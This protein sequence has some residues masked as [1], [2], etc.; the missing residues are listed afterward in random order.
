MIIEIERREPERIELPC[1]RRN[2]RGFL[3]ADQPRNRLQRLLRR[4]RK[5]AQREHVELRK[6]RGRLGF[7]PPISGGVGTPTLVQMVS[8][9]MD[10]IAGSG[11]TFT[12]SLL[13]G[14]Q[15]G[16]CLTLM[17]WIN[18][19][20][21]ITS[22]ADDQSQSWTAEHSFTTGT[23]NNAYIFSKKNTAAGVKKITVT[24]PSGELAGG[25][26]LIFN[27]AEWSNVDQTTPIANAGHN[28]VTSS[29]TSWAHSSISPTSG[30][31]IVHGAVQTLG[32]F[33]DVST[34]FSAGASF[35]LE[36][37]D[38]FDGFC[39]QSRVAP[40]GAVT[41]TITSGASTPYVSLAF[42]LIAADAGAANP[43]AF[44][45]KRAS[46][47]N[48]KTGGS[49]GTTHTFQFPQD[50]NLLVCA[51]SILSA[52]VSLAITGFTDVT[53]GGSNHSPVTNGGG[54]IVAQ[55]HKDNVTPSRTYS[56]TATFGADMSGGCTMWFLDFVGA[57]AA[58]LDT[59][60]VRQATGNQTV[61]GNLTTHTVTPTGTAI[62]VD[63]LDHDAGSE[64]DVTDSTIAFVMPYA[65]Q[66]GAAGGNWT[67]DSALAIKRASAGVTFTYTRS[68]TAAGLWEC[69]SGGYTAAAAAGA[70]TPYQPWQQRSPLV[71]A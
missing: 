42:A 28:E 17:I 49:T 10:T 60:C 26:F 71:A 33:A 1:G 16:N 69:I 53:D 40:G 61:A 66:D 59:A 54:G 58:P 27:L 22:V 37:A 20:N 48:T 34:V 43:N 41:P 32:S 36:A 52:V 5:R 62:I 47:Q 57:A 63:Y 4:H 29:T 19:G 13:E 14:S 18:S 23:N 15:A 25:P 35:S 12:L 67:M 55:L 44:W 7:I 6:S 45:V 9:P 56:A 8:A 68:A 64:T 39:V 38:M 46:G 2:L 70:Q 30:N 21:T 11:T 3:V 50:G 65:G 24:L 31:L 51:S